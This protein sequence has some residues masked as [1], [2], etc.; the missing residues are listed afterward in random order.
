MEDRLRAEAKELVGVAKGDVHSS[1]ESEFQDRLKK[2]SEESA[3]TR[4]EEVKKKQDADI[5][6]WGNQLAIAVGNAFLILSVAATFPNAK[7][8]TA[9]CAWDDQPD[10]NYLFAEGYN[11]VGSIR[12]RDKVKVV[13]GRILDQT[14][15][16]IPINLGLI[17][18]TG[19]YEHDVEAEKRFRHFE[20]QHPG[21]VETATLSEGKS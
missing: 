10:L 12:S 17:N 7:I 14:G 18:Q 4:F 8:E 1:L 13:F 11:W 5:S 20:K 15:K 21:V 9:T 16:P 2:L 3:K 6:N 19:D